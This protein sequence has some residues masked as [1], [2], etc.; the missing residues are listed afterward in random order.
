MSAGNHGDNLDATVEA[1]IDALT[2]DEKVDMLA[3]QMEFWS[4]LKQLLEEDYYHKKP[5]PAA[6]CERVGLPGVH[7]IDG[8]RGIVLEGGATTFPVSMARGAS[9]DVGLE[10]DIGDAIGKEL[11]ALG[12]NLFGGVCINL[13]RHPAWGRAQETYGEEPVHLGAFGAALAEG[14]ERHGLACVKHYAANSMENARFKVDVSMSPRVLHEIYLPH[15]KD[16]V[17]AGAS[18]VMSA[19]NAVNGE[20]C[21][22]NEELLTRILKDRWKF[23]GFVL[24]DFVFGMRDGEKAAHA[25]LDLEMPYRLFWGDRLGRMVKQGKVAESEL[26]D[27][28][29]RLIRAQ[30]TLTERDYP[31]SWV[32]HADHKALARKAAE[33]SMVLLKNEDALLPLADTSRIV[34]LGKLAAQANLGDRGSSDGRPDYVVT[35][36][37]GLKARFDAVEHF[38]TLGGHEDAVR[39]ADAVIVV[40]GYT[41]EHEGEYVAPGEMKLISDYAPPP[42]ALGFLDRFGLGRSLWKRVVSF[43]MAAQAKKAEANENSDEAVFAVGGDRTSL[44]LLPDD[45]AM[46]L[47]A[48][49]LNPNLAVAIMSGSAVTMERWK[50]RAKAVLMT[51]YPGMEGG[52]AFAGIVSGD[53]N[54]SGHLPFVVPTDPDHLPFFDKDA[55]AITYDLWHGQRK[56]DRDGNA[57]AFPLG[58]GLSYTTFK[59]GKAKAERIGDN[60][61]VSARV[62]NTGKRA[63]DDVIQIYASVPDSRVERAPRELKGFARV[64]LDP[65]KTETVA[66]DIPLSKLAYFD[67]AEDDF[68]LE[69]AAYTFHVSRF[70]GDPAAQS[71]TLELGAA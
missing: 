9:W 36:L 3:G 12:G 57:P 38:D 18:V 37:D 61:R 7:F 43:A 40:A 23:D 21:G 30:L 68:V 59:I 54:P 41:Y 13:L 45:E 56:L 14:V 63:G 52:H 34:V 28:L 50:D 62:T 27:K 17:D 31:K 48:A 42:P 19:Y 32:G 16:T 53:V 20:W 69:R 35:L 22:E 29:R 26:D 46:I 66:V 5:F 51:W 4:G 60:V 71:V 44:D 6:R 24:T 65:G 70:A 33:R 1:K 47:A 49:E 11:R 2:L 8:P 64:S 55:R 10:R 39:G 67:E 15:F 25:G 58:W